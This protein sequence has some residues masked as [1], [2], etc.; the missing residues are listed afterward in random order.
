MAYRMLCSEP[1][2]CQSVPDGEWTRAPELDIRGCRRYRNA[3]TGLTVLVPVIWYNLTPK[4][5]A[6]QLRYHAENSERSAARMRAARSGYS[7]HD[8]RDMDRQARRLRAMAI[9]ADRSPASTAGKVDWMGLGD[10]SRSLESEA[11]A[12]AYAEALP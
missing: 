5:E 6:A 9:L 4:E 1:D 12:V 11:A 8:A 3:E 10:P 7:E 2:F